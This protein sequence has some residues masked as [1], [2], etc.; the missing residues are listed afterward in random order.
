TY[1]KSLISIPSWG[2]KSLSASPEY[3]PNGS[4]TQTHNCGTS[5]KFE[6]HVKNLFG[7]TGGRILAVAFLLVAAI[8]AFYVIQILLVPFV[9]ALFVVYLFDPAILAM[10]RRGLDRGHA[11]I[12]LFLL[13]VISAA[14]L[15]MLMPSWLRLESL[16][17][18]SDT[19]TK[20]VTAQVSAG[21]NWLN[22]NFPM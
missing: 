18:S 5:G 3:C 7:D 22:A 19:F 12:V 21:Q 11:F 14:V 8:L 2:P 4:A 6:A 20:R 10:Q 17:V 9:A 15:L 1:W 13:T 16:G